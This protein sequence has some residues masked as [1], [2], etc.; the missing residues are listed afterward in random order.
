VAV[1]GQVDVWIGLDVGK[2]QHFADVLDDQ[3][4]RLF[5]QAVANDQADLEALLE[6]AAGHG[7]PGLVIDQPGS[8]AASRRR[9]LTRPGPQPA[10]DRRE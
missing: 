3:G 8:I 6:R 5:A 9:P 7:T 2:D 1:P 10:T 4:E